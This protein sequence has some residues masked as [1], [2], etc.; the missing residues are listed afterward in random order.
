MALA[1][2]SGLPCLPP[3][4]PRLG[5]ATRDASSH[6]RNDGRA[7]RATRTNA[8]LPLTSASAI[9]PGALACQNP[10]PQV[11]LG[12]PTPS[13]ATRTTLLRAMWRSSS[14][15]SLTLASEFATRGYSW[16]PLKVGTRARRLRVGAQRRHTHHHQP[17]N[18]IDMEQPSYPHKSYIYSHALDPFTYS[19]IIIVN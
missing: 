12:E 7:S 2:R 10:A 1:A 19:H 9:C 17:Q 5:A 8:A 16:R 6:P 11:H 15:A 3:G 18:G 13:R 4:C 14:A